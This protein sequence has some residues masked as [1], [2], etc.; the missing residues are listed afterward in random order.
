MSG[1]TRL[2]SFQERSSPV[3][4]LEIKSIDAAN[5]MHANFRV[6][7]CPDPHPRVDKMP[8]L[9]ESTKATKSSVYANSLSTRSYNYRRFSTKATNRSWAETEGSGDDAKCKRWI[10]S[11]LGRKSEGATPL[12]NSWNHCFHW[13]LSIR[14][15]DLSVRK[16]YYMAELQRSNAEAHG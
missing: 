12:R 4:V 6:P 7:V 16:N 9:S 1:A 2:Q 11:E 15:C 8:L 14:C 10:N 3:C 13:V 5:R